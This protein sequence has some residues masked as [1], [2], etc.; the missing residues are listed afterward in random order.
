[1]STTEPDDNLFLALQSYTPR[2]G[3]D[4]KEDFITEAFAWI[5]R[6]HA[7]LAERFLRF[8]LDQC[9]GDFL[10][11][12]WSSQLQWTTQV[13]D[14]NVRLDMVAGHWNVLH[15]LKEHPRPNRWHPL[16]IRRPLLEVMRGTA[17]FEEQVER[18]MVASKEVLEF[19][20][21]GGEIAAFWTRFSIPLPADAPPTDE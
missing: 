5:L 13:G 12:P 1:M 21:R 14:G 7:D 16:H 4:P 3:R 10:T 20:L 19:V 15:H 2:E 9:E 18:F 6:Q 11:G 17:T 8:V